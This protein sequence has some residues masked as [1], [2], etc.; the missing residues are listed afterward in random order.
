[1][2][3]T[4]L[5]SAKFPLITK[6]TGMNLLS[7]E[8]FSEES[9]WPSVS[10]DSKILDKQRDRL[11]ESFKPEIIESYP[12]MVF[13]LNEDRRVVLCNEKLIKN[14]DY[15]TK[16]DI[17]GR[18]P[19]EFLSCINSGCTNGCGTSDA[20]S[21]CGMLK[22]I[23]CALS[24]KENKNECSLLAK[25]DEGIKA[26]NL[27][28]HATPVYIENEKYIIVYLNDISD[29]KLKESMEQIFYHDMLN[30]VNSIVG[31]TSLIIDDMEMSPKELAGLIKERAHFMAREIQGHR[32]IIAAEKSSLEIKTEEFDLPDLLNEVATM[33]SGSSIGDGKDIILNNSERA[34][35]KTDKNILLRITENL[36]KN[37][38]E[39]SFAGQIIHLDYELSEKTALIAV[40]NDS[41]IPKEVQL[42]LFRRS[43]STKGAGRGIGTYSVKILTEKYLNG[44]VGMKSDKKE[45]TTFVV[46]I[47]RNLI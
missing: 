14:F 44:I 21:L 32:M 39:A 2:K 29:S 36:V 9:F 30:A 26:L 11:L 38:L 41:Y 19:G 8:N 40:K 33:F 13:V 5:L 35:I 23:S 34:I 7:Q 17:Y 45:G 18:L 37:A 42:Q 22:A 46:E 3:K 6:Y 27:K 47:P 12:E 1:M 10:I 15:K 24:G 43:F 20:C 31:A 16:N 28:V 25:S 4:Q